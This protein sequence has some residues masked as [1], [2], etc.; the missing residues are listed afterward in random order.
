MLKHGFLSAILLVALH[1]SVPIACAQTGAFID[2]QNADDVRVVS[3]NI[4]RD[5]IFTPGPNADAATPD[6]IARILNA[7]D[8]DVLALQEVY[9]YSASEVA[10]LMDQIAPLPSQNG[11]H[12][13]SNSDNVI[14]SRYPFAL[15][16]GSV[17]HAD[18]LIDLP[19]NV[20]ADDLFI[21]ND[22]L[23]CCSRQQ[24]RQG[25][26]DAI[27]GWLE[28]VRSPGGQVTIAPET[29]MVVLGDFNIVGT[30]APLQTL[31]TGD[32]SFGGPANDSPP[33]WD[34]TALADA[35]PLHNGIGP[36]TYTWRNDSSQFAP[37]VLDYILYTDSVVDV[38]NQFVLNTA[39]MSPAD[40]AATGLQAND[41]I[42]NVSSGFYDHLPVVVDFRVAAPLPGDY[43][44]NGIVD[45]G[46][47][48]TWVN[49]FGAGGALSADGNR[50]GV[51]DL[52]DYTTWRDNLGVSAAAV[53]EPSTLGIAA[54]ALSGLLVREAL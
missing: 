6:R 32:V 40:L 46:D 39:D 44:G 12:A 23:P 50:D 37:G 5:S 13:H 20:Y 31:V 25:E 11:W 26:A 30:G 10:A 34:G 24:E 15:T 9:D 53:P 38:A 49:Q 2:R 29:P 35:R 21:L 17:G 3:F 19:D 27:V 43:D 51:V 28:D 47:Y 16:T 48:T 54:L 41:V 18:A 22:H 8:P 42:I 7:L 1:T 14:V 36:D 4:Y 52:A 33:D 45:T